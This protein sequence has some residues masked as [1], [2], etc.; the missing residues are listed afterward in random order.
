MAPLKM[1]QQG[2]QAKDKASCGQFVL[3][4]AERFKTYLLAGEL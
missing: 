2:A 1:Y 4:V 3:S